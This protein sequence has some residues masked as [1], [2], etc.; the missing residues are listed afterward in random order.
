MAAK[1]RRRKGSCGCR[2]TI[3]RAATPGDAQAAILRSPAFAHPRGPKEGNDVHWVTSLVI[4]AEIA[5]W[6]SDGL[7]RH[8]SF[9]GMREDKSANSVI[10]KTPR[11]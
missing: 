1:L 2:R 7:I 3:V 10:V 11:A 6:T 8:A 5:S 4:E 9:K